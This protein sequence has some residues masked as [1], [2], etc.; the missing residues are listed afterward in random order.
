MIVFSLSMPETEK[1]PIAEM[2]FASKPTFTSFFTW[3]PSTAYGVFHLS[4]WSAHFFFLSW[5]GVSRPLRKFLSVTGRPP[6]KRT[7]AHEK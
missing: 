5:K 6:I 1:Y 3:V 4:L 7:I 2:W